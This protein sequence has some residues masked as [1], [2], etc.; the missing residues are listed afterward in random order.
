MA[1]PPSP[2]HGRA[3]TRPSS[4]RPHP[5]PSP[6]PPLPGV[7][8]R[9]PSPRHGRAPT[10]PSSCRPRPEPSPSPP[11]PGVANRPTPRHGPASTRPSSCR[12][13][14]EPSPSPPLPGAANRPPLPPSWPGPDPAIL[15]PPAPRAFPLPASAARGKPPP[16]PRHGRAPTRPSSCRPH[17]EPFPSPPLPGVAK[18]V[19]NT[20]AAR[21]CTPNTRMHRAL[22][23]A[24]F[25]SPPPAL[26]GPESHRGQS[27][28][29]FLTVHGLDPTPPA[30]PHPCPWRA[31]P[32]S[33][34]G[35]DP[36][37]LLPPAPRTRPANRPIRTSQA[38]PLAANRNLTPPHRAVCRHP[39]HHP[40][41]S[42]RSMDS[43]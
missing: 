28:S 21:R 15:L 38:S 1:R 23:T 5:E 6:S 17:P 22:R 9:P 16:V 37:I 3:P 41:P 7:A 32:P 35:P 33:W 31:P 24:S 2:R 14:P 20:D 27:S 36:A 30:F 4:G 18:Q 10:R 39:P 19:C 11:L 12:P 13:C 29:R 34:P 25:S 43:I 42:S 8:N 26:R 40:P